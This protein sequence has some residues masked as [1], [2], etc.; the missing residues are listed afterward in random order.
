MCDK[1]S[2]EKLAS[3]KVD[4]TRTIS[5]IL[6]TLILSGIAIIFILN[7]TGYSP[8]KLETIYK[9]SLFTF[10]IALLLDIQQYEIARICVNKIIQ[11]SD[12][13][14]IER[15]RKIR[16]PNVIS[17]FLNL[18]YS[19]KITAVIIAYILILLQVAPI[20]FSLL[21]LLILSLTYLFFRIFASKIITSFCKRELAAGIKP[22]E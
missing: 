15:T 6:R 10:I 12:N 8:E 18:F 16:T 9:F 14:K 22:Q 7:D 2:V 19:L 21:T 5:H 17:F 4:F 3:Q 1:T 11:Y 13:N 20:Y